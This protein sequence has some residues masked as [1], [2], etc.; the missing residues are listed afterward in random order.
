LLRHGA[1]FCFGAGRR[2]GV[3]DEDSG[4]SSTI[5]AEV[6][7][8]LRSFGAQTTR[9]SGQCA[10]RPMFTG[11]NISPVKRARVLTIG[12]HLP[13]WPD[14]RKSVLKVPNHVTNLIYSVLARNASPLGASARLIHLEGWSYLPLPSASWRMRSSGTPAVR[15]FRGWRKR[16]KIKVVYIKTENRL[17]DSSYGW[18]SLGLRVCTCGLTSS[19]KSKEKGRRGTLREPKR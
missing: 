6:A 12:F 13:D 8:R 15:L 10:Q 3:C 18:H 4:R 11:L 9:A 5:W 14:Y 2:S 16:A 1:F 7:Q 17:P 19:A